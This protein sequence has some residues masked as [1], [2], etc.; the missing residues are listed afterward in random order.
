MAAVSDRGSLVKLYH[1]IS[2]ENYLYVKGVLTF[3]LFQFNACQTTFK[4]IDSYSRHFMRCQESVYCEGIY[5]YGSSFGQR[6]SC[7]IVSH[8]F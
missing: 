6:V 1:I 3:I 2:K 4:F 7:K 8:Y 5:N